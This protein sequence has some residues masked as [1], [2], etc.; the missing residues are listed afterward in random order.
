MFNNLLFAMIACSSI[1]FA[2]EEKIAIAGPPTSPIVGQLVDSVLLRGTEDVFLEGDYAYL[3]CREGQR[4]TI[5][6]IK[7][8]ARPKIVSSFTHPKLG[9]AAGFAISGNTVYLTSMSTSRL[10]VID[11]TDKSAPRLLG[12]VLIGKKGVLYKAAY[13]DGFCYI[14]NLT[15]K[16]LFVVDVRNPKQPVVTGSVAVT[17]ENDGPFSVLL[18]GDYALV[19]T[20]FGNRNRLAVV[21]V[22][23][24]E[25]PR[26]VTQIFGPE[27]GQVSGDVVDNL[28][29]S[30]YW[31]KNAFLIFDIADP[32]KPRLQAK[33]ID[34]RLG[35]PNRCIVSGNRAYLPMIEGNG[36]AVLD[37]SNPKKPKFL[38]SFSDPVLLKK[39]YGVA[40]RDN[41]LFVASRE[42]NSLVILDRDALEIK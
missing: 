3:P 14:P 15:E 38:S 10:L 18:H 22:K 30:V 4:L 34:N 23:N 36:V 13:R 19:G 2:V 21:N 9:S 12:S 32:G 39:T 25:K 8:P 33:L 28:Y 6:S 26:L 17:T 11:V 31:D 7:D 37:I 27:I 35:K 16:K 20:I 41:L 1:H 40:V 5:C 24:P 42:G 29:Y